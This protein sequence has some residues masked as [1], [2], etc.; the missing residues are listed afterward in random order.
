VRRSTCGCDGPTRSALLGQTF[1]EPE[2]FFRRLP[3]DGR[4]SADS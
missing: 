3:G 2:L 4:I 1:F